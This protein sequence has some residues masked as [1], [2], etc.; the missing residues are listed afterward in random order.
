M[1]SAF[2]SSSCYRWHAVRKVLWHKNMD[3]QK[4]LPWRRGVV[5]VAIGILG[6]GACASGSTIVEKPR[7]GTLSGD[8]NDRTYTPDAGFTGRDR[9]TWRVNDGVAES[10]LAEVTIEVSAANVQ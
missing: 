8:D 5:L 1:D 4:K 7:H 6:A 10:A 3:E 9:F 2:Q